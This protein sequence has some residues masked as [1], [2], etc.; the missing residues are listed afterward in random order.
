LCNQKGL[1]FASKTPGR[2]QHINYFS[3][4]GA[5][6]AQHRKDPTII[7]EIEC[8]L[9]DLPG[10]GYAEVSGNAKLHWQR[11]LGDYVQRRDQ[12]AALILIMDSRRP[13]T[14]LDIQMLEWFAPTGKPIHCI[15]TK[16]DKLNRNESVNVLRQTKAKL[17][18]YVDEDGE[19]FPFTVQLFSALK[20]IGIEEANDKIL[21]LAGIS[22]DEA[23]AQVELIEME[24]SPEDDADSD[25]APCSTPHA[26]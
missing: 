8:L 21:E 25:A 22:D 20:R 6:V 26:K 4:G 2:T 13:F 11:L 16:V 19:G 5:H 12:L 14:D 10:Y 18:S 3:I 24:D 7:E 23:A 1:A 9:V 15:L 17:D